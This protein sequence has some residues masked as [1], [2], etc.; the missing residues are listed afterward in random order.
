MALEEKVP[1]IS[2]CVKFLFK[3]LIRVPGSIVPVPRGTMRNNWLP[4]KMAE[5]QT[6]AQLKELGD[7]VIERDFTYGTRQERDRIAQEK[8]E[9]AKKEARKQKLA[10]KVAQE[11]A[12]TEDKFTSLEL[13]TIQ[14]EIEAP[15]IV[16]V[17]DVRS[18]P[19]LSLSFD[20]G[21]TN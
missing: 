14:T 11:A 13:P 15:A 20:K 18:Y 7:V 5:Y 10:L 1:I 4:R 21:K 19:I 17:Q 6:M 3:M 2:T 12:W 16:E 8:K 9:A